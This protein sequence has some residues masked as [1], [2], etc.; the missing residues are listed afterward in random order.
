MAHV[1]LCESN[2]DHFH[3]FPE[4]NRTMSLLILK[5]GV[6]FLFVLVCMTFISTMQAADISTS[7]IH[8]PLP[9]CSVAP[10]RHPLPAVLRC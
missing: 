9:I 6:L 7:L 3:P 2:K 5:Q 4:S 1:C 10:A 8:H